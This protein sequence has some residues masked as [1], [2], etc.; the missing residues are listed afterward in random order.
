MLKV[1]KFPCHECFV[2]C[3]EPLLPLTVVLMCHSIA[4]LKI[5]ETVQLIDESALCDEVVKE[6]DL[7]AQIKDGLFKQFVLRLTELE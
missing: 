5:L 7:L 3:E 2:R 6:L 1:L 4:E